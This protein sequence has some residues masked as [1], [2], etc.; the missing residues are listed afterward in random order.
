MFV[1]VPAT[2]RSANAASASDTRL[3]ADDRVAT[4]DRRRALSTGWQF[5]DETLGLYLEMPRL[6]KDKRDKGPLLFG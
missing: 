6:R 1:S 5:I 2:P 4:P 3:S